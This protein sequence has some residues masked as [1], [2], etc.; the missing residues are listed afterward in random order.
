MWRDSY[1]NIA[2]ADAKDD[3]TLVV[4]LKAKSAPFLSQL[5]MPGV[6]IVSEKAVTTKGDG[7]AEEPVSS[8]AFVLKKRW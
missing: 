2:S 6:S 3:H 4:T 5:A 7:Y 1:Q 8:G